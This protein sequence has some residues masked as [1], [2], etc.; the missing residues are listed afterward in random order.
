MM[1]NR[2]SQNVAERNLLRVTLSKII[3]R[4]QS[5]NPCTATHSGVSSEITAATSDAASPRAPRRLRR[6]LKL[7]SDS[8][9]LSSAGGDAIGGLHRTGVIAASSIARLSRRCAG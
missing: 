9:G 7:V 5:H 8:A 6:P 1:I 2:Q 3:D 4:P